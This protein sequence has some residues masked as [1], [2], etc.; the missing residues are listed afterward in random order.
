MQ[1]VEQGRGELGD[2]RV[3]TSVSSIHQQVRSWQECFSSASLALRST[4]R[5]SPRC[6]PWGTLFTERI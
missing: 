2:R 4:G 6:Q 5:S 1:D 3:P